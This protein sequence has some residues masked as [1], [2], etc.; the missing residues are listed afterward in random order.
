MA[1]KFYWDST[2]TIDA[3]VSAGTTVTTTYTDAPGAVTNEAYVNDQSVAALVTSFGNDDA[4]RFDFTSSVTARYIAVY[5]DAQETD[6]LDIYAGEHATNMI[7]DQAKLISYTTTFTVG[8]NIIDIGASKTG[9]YWFIVADGAIA[10]LA[11]IFIGELFTFPVGYDLRNTKGAIYGVD[12]TES[13]GGIE[14]ANKRH[15]AKGIWNW[16]WSFL[17]ETAKDNLVTMRED[18]DF[19]RLKFIYDDETTKNWVRLVGGLDMTEVV[20]QGYNTT[21]SLRGQLE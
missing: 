9:R 6:N 12:V 4:I 21:V 2:K 3:T 14:S 17:S 16:S 13:Y 8:W 20:F 1:K 15:G 19:N 7:N 10:N 18:I 5:F 11:E